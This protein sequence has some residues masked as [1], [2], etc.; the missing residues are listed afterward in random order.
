MAE[1]V[2]VVASASQLAA[3]C[4][5][6][7]DL[8]RKIKGAETLLQKYQHQLQDL[9]VLSGYISENPLLQ[10]SREVEDCTNSL[11]LLIDRSQLHCV[12]RK[13]RFSR[14]WYLLQREKDLQETFATL[15]RQKASLSLVVEH[16]QACALHKI[17]AGVDAMAT[18]QG[19][20]TSKTG[21]SPS[22]SGARR[23]GILKRGN[24]SKKLV[25]DDSKFG[26]LVK[27]DMFQPPATS[28]GNDETEG[29]DAIYDGCTT[30]GGNQCNGF[31]YAG[32]GGLFTNVGDYDLKTQYN[33]CDQTGPG[34]QVNGLDLQITD[35]EP[36]ATSS[37]LPLAEP[38]QL[39]RALA[40]WRR[41]RSSQ[42]GANQEGPISA[43]KLGTQYNGTRIRYVERAV[44]ESVEYGDI[45]TQQGREEIHEQKRQVHD[46]KKR[47]YDKSTKG[48]GRGK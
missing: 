24:S 20:T 32:P 25:E 45:S 21:L 44:P 43:T 29:G 22:D 8:L 17:Q 39:P 33:G 28:I 35:G 26:Q 42:G 46:G 37:S 27:R 41:C 31:S 15:E 47:K 19:H 36:L 9:R 48:K 2:G 3:L 7:V 11:L 12:L 16:V 5:S 18:K 30:T 4:L 13:N 23:S 38:P 6:L 10:T 1:V 40:V 34:D 14:T